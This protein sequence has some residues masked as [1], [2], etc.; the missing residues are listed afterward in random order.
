M[1]SLQI[2]P[3]GDIDLFRFQLAVDG[4]TAI[5]SLTLDSAQGDLRLDILNSTGVSI[6]QGVP[7]TSTS[8]FVHVNPP[9]GTYYVRIRGAAGIENNYDL[10]IE[11]WGP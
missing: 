10:F 1:D 8:V 11:T 7:M 3:V 5:A 9:A 6:E 4:K 2:C